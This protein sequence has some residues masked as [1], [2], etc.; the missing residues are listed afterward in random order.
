[1]LISQLVI[2]LLTAAQAV[3]AVEI[4]GIFTSF[5]SL[6]F[7]HPR[8]QYTPPD[9]PTWTAFIVTTPEVDLVASG[10]TYATC[11]LNAGEEF[12]PF[13]TVQCTVSDNV[14]PGE[15]Y[16]GEVSLPFSFNAGGS[17]SSTDIEASRCF[18]PGENTITFTD[19]D[20]RLSI[21][22]YFDPNPTDPSG[23]VSAQKLIQSLAQ[24]LALVIL[25]ECPNGYRSGTLGISS[26]AEG[27][28]IDC[29]SAQ[30]GLTSELNAWVKPV[31]ALDFPYTSECT[32]S[33]FSISF[34]NIQPG[35]R[36]F[37]NALATVP[38]DAAYRVNY[39]VRYQCVGGDYTDASMTKLWNPYQRLE[40]DLYGQVIV[41]TTRTVTEATTYVTTLPFDP[42]IQN[43]K[44]VEVVKQIPLTT[45]TD[46][47]V[48]VTTRTSTLAAVI[49]QTGTVLVETP[50]HL[51][52][53]ITSFWSEQYTSTLTEIASLDSIDTVLVNYPVNPSTTITS[54]WNEDYST[55]Y[56][57][58]NGIGET[59]YV[60][61]MFPPN[62]TLTTQEFWTGS[63]LRWEV[64][65]DEPGGTDTLLLLAPANPTTTYFEFWDND[66]A[67]TETSTYGPQS[68]DAVIIYVPPNPTITTTE[69]WLEGYTTT[70][71]QEQE[72]NETDY[73]VIYV[74]PNPTITTTEFWIDSFTTSALH[75][76]GP[77]DTDTL[78]VYVP[79]NPT[80][81]SA[82]FWLENQMSTA[83]ETNAPEGTDYVIVYY[84][85]NEVLTRTE[86]WSED[87]TSTTTESNNPQ[88]T[89]H[90]IVYVPANPTIR[91]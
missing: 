27:Y 17:G 20:N 75:T 18:V 13:S 91:L 35:Y 34:L 3:L 21:Q 10:Q 90:V 23:L 42:A 5:E 83:T 51:T 43:T 22:A 41:I 28:N 48:G 81:T 88:E 72:P 14:E 80:I 79:H 56:T 7:S 55:T 49:G 24:S 38:S 60:F 77:Q 85:Y 53:T 1:M 71:T 87:Y 62:P 59:D 32:S 67:T 26:T 19:G 58:T 46:S 29:N 2:S 57:E 50:Y 9:F 40:A 70:V 11:R 39:D 65:T 64:L 8:L 84:P 73:V 74:P 44:T 12:V 30:A 54:I 16:N 68:T 89:D 69:F 37:L 86:F 63:D 4:S 82:Q 45:I 66:Y 15:T 25:P 31:D 76:M 61:V 52:T 6:T 47:Y 33:G 78:V 36:V